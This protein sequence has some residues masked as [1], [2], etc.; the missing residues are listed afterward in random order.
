MH[1]RYY[2]P[3]EEMNGQACWRQDL[4]CGY[5][6]YVGSRHTEC[7]LQERADS[8][9]VG[10]HASSG[11]KVSRLEGQRRNLLGATQIT[12]R[13]PLKHQTLPRT[14]NT[15]CMLLDRVLEPRQWLVR[16]CN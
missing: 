1:E 5:P 12:H 11:R 2:H 9:W 14:L 7:V 15:Y 16:A 8:N 13:E 4:C 6:S 3:C 10:T